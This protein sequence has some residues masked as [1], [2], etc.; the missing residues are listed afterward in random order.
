MKAKCLVTELGAF[1][2]KEGCLTNGSPSF[3]ATSAPSQNAW[4]ASFSNPQKARSVNFTQCWKHL[5][6]RD[7]PVKSVN[8]F[9]GMRALAQENSTNYKYQKGLK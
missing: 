1:Q 9:T 6:T 8:T 3:H 4:S 7:L 2:S 5:S